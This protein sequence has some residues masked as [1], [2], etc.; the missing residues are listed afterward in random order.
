ML[1][2]NET[3][4]QLVADNTET[5]APILENSIRSISPGWPRFTANTPVI[6]AGYSRRSIK[7]TIEYSCIKSIADA[8][9]AVRT[10]R[11]GATTPRAVLP[12]RRA[13]RQKPGPGP[14]A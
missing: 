9:I 12:R 2:E 8:R 13:H 10:I 14:P 4:L 11:L 7:T 5:I 3:Y 1:D 6:F